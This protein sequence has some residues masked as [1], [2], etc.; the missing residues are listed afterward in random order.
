MRGFLLALF[1]VVIPAALA[2][3]CFYLLQRGN[4]SMNVKRLDELVAEKRT[5]YAAEQSCQAHLGKAK[6]DAQTAQ[7]ELAHRQETEKAKDA[8]LHKT[9]PPPPLVKTAGPRK[10]IGAKS[11]QAALEEGGTVKLEGTA[12]IELTAK[13]SSPP[14]G[15]A[16]TTP[17][18]SKPGSPSAMPTPR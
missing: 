10:L 14:G 2:G 9:P 8:A 16:R 1:H 12:H 4:E 18:P 11:S 3:L 7:A 13:T 6:L 15:Q 17:E 5:L